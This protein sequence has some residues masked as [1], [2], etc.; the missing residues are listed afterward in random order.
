MGTINLLAWNCRGSGGGLCSPTMNHL[1]RIS[2]ATNAKN[3]NALKT[4]L[5][6]D[7][8]YVVPA[9]GQLGGLWLLWKH[10]V[11]L[12][13][14]NMSPNYILVEGVYVPLAYSFSLVCVYGDPHHTIT[15]MIWQDVLKL[16]RCL[17]NAE[18]IASFP[19]TSVHHLPMLYSDHCPILIKMESTIQKTKKPFNLKILWIQGPD[20]Q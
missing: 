15:D 16:D 9:L 17:A 2:S 14:I 11:S 8:A 18:W 10:D 1:G 6:I 13:V 3:I 5:A 7:N 19:N 4:K 12:K 20:Y